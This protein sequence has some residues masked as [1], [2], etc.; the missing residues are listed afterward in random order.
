MR[1]ALHEREV[2]ARLLHA[3][4]QAADDRLAA[5]HGLALQFEHETQHTVGRRV[6]RL[7]LDPQTDVDDIDDTDWSER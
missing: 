3:G 2:L 5:Q 4:V 1:A 6:L 7:M